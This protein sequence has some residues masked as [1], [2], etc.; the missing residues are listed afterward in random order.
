VDAVCNLKVIREALNKTQHEM[1]A[2]LGVSARAVQSYEQGWRPFPPQVQKMAGLLFFLH[3]RKGPRKLPPCWK[4]R[5]CPPAIRDQ[6]VAY[7]VQ[8]GD[9]CW[10]ITGNACL[11]KRYKS[12]N[13]KLAE[14]KNCPVLGHCQQP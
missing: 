7:Q 14:C 4:L 8:A 12:W 9:L 10:L 2:L 3:H 1:A 11:G 13:A 5:D 6:C